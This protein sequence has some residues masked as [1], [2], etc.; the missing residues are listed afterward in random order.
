MIHIEFLDGQGLGNQLWLYASAKGIAKKMDY[1]LTI[2]GVQKFKGAKFLKLESQY[3]YS[4]ENQLSIVR[5]QF[6]EKQFFDKNMG[7]F[8]S[9]FDSEVLG[10]S[11]NTYIS[12]VFQS[13]NYFFGLKSELHMWLKLCDNWRDVSTKYHDVTVLNIRGGEYKRFSN[14]ILPKSYWE[15][16][17]KNVRNITGNNQF[18]VVTDDRAYA[19]SLFPKLPIVSDSIA[20]CYA[21]IYGAKNLVVSN[22][23][24]AYFP[25]CTR[26]DKPLVIAPYQWSRFNNKFDLWAAPC[27]VNMDWSW[28]KPNGDLASLTEVKKNILKTQQYY[29]TFF[30]VCHDVRIPAE[31]KMRDWIPKSI[32]RQTKIFLSRLFPKLIG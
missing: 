23:S 24:F 6:F 25:V 10:L 9:D 29:S 2:H 32:R 19:K 4:N 14:L 18:V 22:S 3:Q 7:Y 28:Q 13:E 31:R 21:A 1:G 12:G 11:E 5:S 30:K 27:N 16:A 26:L 20:E 15:E 17:I 8:A